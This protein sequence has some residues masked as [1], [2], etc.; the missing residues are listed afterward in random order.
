LRASSC[1]QD[2]KY[3]DALTASDLLLNALT[4]PGLPPL[5]PLPQ[6]AAQ[7]LEELDA[8]PRLAAHL[9]A[10][11]DVACQITDWLAA[12][13][14][15]LRFCHEAVL[16]G[17]ATH[18]IGKTEHL[19]ELSGPGSAHEEAGQQL[20]LSHGISPRLA[21]FAATHATW[22]GPDI[23]LEDL[24]VSLADKIWK[25]KR[26]P[27]LEDLFMNRLTT[28]SGRSRW[29]EFL[30]LDDLLTSIGQEADQRLAFQASYLVRPY[31]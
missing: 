5:R 28:A 6:R 16:F 8:P 14:P 31:G 2:A 24:L 11:H 30:V 10:V 26:V 3:P 9:R 18:D 23:Q 1:I 27:G 22:T 12:Q 21:R 4:S 13:Y 15:A 20:L 29:E 25:D 7:L 17:A 19:A